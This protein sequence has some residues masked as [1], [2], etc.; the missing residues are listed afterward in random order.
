MLSC[1]CLVAIVVGTV[2]SPDHSQ[3]LDVHD[4]CLSTGDLKGKMRLTGLLATVNIYRSFKRQLDAKV[5]TSAY[6]LLFP[7]TPH[8]HTHRLLLLTVLTCNE[9]AQEYFERKIATNPIP[10]RY[11]I[12][13][14][15]L[16]LLSF[17]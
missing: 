1:R 2:S 17:M 13:L 14:S 3:V 8:Q 6:P 15:H 10:V 11:A 7:V 16:E 5:D 12:P 4:V 9:I